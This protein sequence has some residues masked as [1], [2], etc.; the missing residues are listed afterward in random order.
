MTW[1]RFFWLMAP[2]GLEA[3]KSTVS[4]CQTSQIAQLALNGRQFEQVLRGKL[5][6]LTWIHVCLLLPNICL[7]NFFY[8]WGNKLPSHLWPHI[9]SAASV[10][11][12]L[13]ILIVR[14]PRKEGGLGNCTLFMRM[15]WGGKESDDLSLK[16]GA[17]KGVGTDGPL[18]ISERRHYLAA[19]SHSR[20]SLLWR[21]S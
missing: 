13:T 21:G 11:S 5:C 14:H 1:R 15:W 20:L 16:R 17:A 7:H 6:A 10:L 2:P 9:T 12:F 4:K 18:P 19:K 8:W 3:E